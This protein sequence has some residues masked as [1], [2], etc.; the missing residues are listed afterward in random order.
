MRRSGRAGSSAGAS[1]AS[2]PRSARLKPRLDRA[3]VLRVSTVD[4]RLLERWEASQRWRRHA[5]AREAAEADVELMLAR[6]LRHI[7]RRRAETANAERSLEL[8]DR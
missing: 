6:A 2:R 5:R 4:Y 1:T 7:D 8:D 3:D